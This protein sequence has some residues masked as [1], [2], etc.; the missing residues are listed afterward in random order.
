[1]NHRQSAVLFKRPY[2][3]K[4][5]TKTAVYWYYVIGPDGRRQRFSLG[6]TS[7]TEARYLLTQ[8]I[9]EGTLIPNRKQAPSFGE[10]TKDFWIW[11]LC[12]HVKGHLIRGER[13]SQKGSGKTEDT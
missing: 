4:D 10:F 8:K 11:D 2:A 1:M 5:G 3:L 7:K 6:T 13:I 12:V 9:R